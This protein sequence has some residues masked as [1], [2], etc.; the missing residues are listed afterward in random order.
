[1]AV[2]FLDDAWDEYLQCKMEIGKRCG[3]T[4]QGCAAF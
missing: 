4:D 3:M 1:M 2:E